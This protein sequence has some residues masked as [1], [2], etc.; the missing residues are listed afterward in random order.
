MFKKDAK[1]SISKGQ[2]W[3]IEMTSTTLTSR[4]KAI[5]IGYEMLGSE[6]P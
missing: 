5:N 6:C 4:T 2:I 3:N 1:S